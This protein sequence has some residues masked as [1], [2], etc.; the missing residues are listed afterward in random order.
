MKK[1]P[2]ILA[3]AASILL[4][5]IVLFTSL[6]LVAKDESFI[7]NEYTKIG[8]ASEMGMTNVD[9]VRSFTR[10][11]DYM[12]GRVST[13][14]IEVTVNGEKQD[15]FALEQ[16]RSHMKDVRT[17]WLAVRQYRDLAIMACLILFLLA[18]VLGFRS[19]PATL[20]RGYL[21]GFFICA[22]FFG[23]F[24]SWALLDFS[25]FWTMFHESLFW[26]DMWLFDPSESRMI[27]MLPES[28]FSDIILRTVLYM[29]A[30]LIALLAA[31]VIC[32]TSLRRTKER[33]RAEKER[34]RLIKERKAAG[35]PIE[36][37]L[38]SPAQRK[39][40]REKQR[41]EARR[42]EELKKKQLQRQKA[43]EKA[44]KDAERE[45]EKQLL[46][47]ALD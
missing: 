20:S 10:L 11:V 38:L 13:I 18:V 9:L 3:A 19:A 34:R 47:A 14:G 29:G 12:E 32:L 44:E 24:G 4:V 26:N 7:N 36:D 22:L 2:V 40:R 46:L 8:V 43:K 15:M 39:A 37:E 45:K 41:E 5:F 30:V 16:E 21:Y 17:L 6:Q 31:S 25:S 42:A 23:F 27:N 33:M 28:I 1:F 35:L